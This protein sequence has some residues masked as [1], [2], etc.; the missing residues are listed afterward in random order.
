MKDLK[1]I[2]VPIIITTSLV[3]FGCKN[4]EIKPEKKALS[5]CNCEEILQ[6]Q[7]YRYLH[8]KDHGLIY[9]TCKM[10]NG[11]PVIRTRYID[12]DYTVTF[13]PK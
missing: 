4:K 2:I 11:K 10:E 1:S 3:I 13:Y 5:S 6:N 7:P 12:E 9:Q 8:T